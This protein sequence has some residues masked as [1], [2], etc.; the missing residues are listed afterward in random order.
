MAA[1]HSGA[2]HPRMCLQRTHQLGMFRQA[3]A[4]FFGP[5]PC[6][7]RPATDAA[8]GKQAGHRASPRPGR[9]PRGIK[10]LNQP[11]APAFA[12]EPAVCRGTRQYG[13]FAR[14]AQGHRVL[15][16][17]VVRRS[18]LVGV[19]TAPER[20]SGPGVSQ[21]LDYVAFRPGPELE[22]VTASISST[23]SSIS[24]LDAA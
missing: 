5:C 14:P 12:A 20:C 4:H 1:P 22:R 23:N 24:G 17:R 10:Q 21:A 2:P 7:R 6:K 13:V 3:I 18:S 19:R 9:W 8:S 11:V 16:A 15:G